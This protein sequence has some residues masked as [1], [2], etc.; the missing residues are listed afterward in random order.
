M[1]VKINFTYTEVV[2]C[3]YK[4]KKKNIRIFAGLKGIRRGYCPSQSLFKNDFDTVLK[5]WKCSN[6]GVEKKEI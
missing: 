4:Y 6:I 5:K 2:A 1:K 3:L